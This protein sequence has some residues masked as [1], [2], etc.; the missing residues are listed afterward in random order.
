MSAAIINATTERRPQGYR[1]H[2]QPEFVRL[3]GAWRLIDQVVGV[4]LVGQ[5]YVVSAGDEWI[6]LRPR[7]PHEA[8]FKRAVIGRHFGDVFDARKPGRRQLGYTV[9]YSAGVRPTQLGWRFGHLEGEPLGVSVADLAQRFG[10]RVQLDADALEIDLAGL[11][12]DQAGEINLDP[13]IYL[14]S[15]YEFYQSALY[16]Q[17]AAVRSAATG[18]QVAGSQ[19]QATRAQSIIT[20]M[21]LALR[22]D[23]SAVAG[24]VTACILDILTTGYGGVGRDNFHIS[25]C[26]FA[27]SLSDGANYHEVYNRYESAWGIGRAV[28][29]SGN[30]YKSGDFCGAGKPDAGGAFEKTGHFDVGLAEYVHDQQN[31]AP[32]YGEN[33]YVT[34]DLTTGGGSGPYL[35]I[36]AEEQSAPRMLLMGVG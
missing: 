10:E 1:V 2:C 29:D 8:N 14:A 21:R 32:P 11:E 9:L 17:W 5:S 33:H 24:T 3:G 4:R 23:T 12:G 6:E 36:T 28:P 18:V 26:A 27:S 35:D 34:F 13:T 30:W 15:Y 7:W 19:V 20:V 16:N 22:F 31:L 25:K